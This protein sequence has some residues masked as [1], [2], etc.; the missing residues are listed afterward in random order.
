MSEEERGEQE[1]LAQE[2]TVPEPQEQEVETPQEPEGDG[3]RLGDLQK[4]LENLKGVLGKQ[5]QELGQLRNEN[6]YYRQSLQ[7]G[8]QQGFQQPQQHPQQTGSVDE[9]W[10]WTDPNA[11][12]KMVRSETG[13]LAQ[14]VHNVLA[15]GAYA[16][17]RAIMSV[18]RESF[19]DVREEVGML[20]NQ[21]VNNPT[22]DPAWIEDPDSWYTVAAAARVMKQRKGQG[23]PYKVNPVRPTPTETPSSVKPKDTQKRVGLSES[24]RRMA[25][26]LG[27][28]EKEAEEAIRQEK[29]QREWEAS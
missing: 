3:G 15:K 13:Q 7:Q 24:Q 8:Q 2:E 23:Q 1:P 16:R 25:K 10:D 5:G 17:G 29:E 26:E 19:D 12:R 27:L 22:V 14:A 6:A 4:E 21:F 28:S 18:D 9:D 20:M 11:V